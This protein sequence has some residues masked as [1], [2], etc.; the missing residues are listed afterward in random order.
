MSLG[1]LT[2]AIYV[3]LHLQAAQVCPGGGKP[4]GRFPLL[5]HGDGVHGCLTVAR[6]L[7]E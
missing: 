5:P 1:P 2:V 3:P 4:F 6:Q 7:E